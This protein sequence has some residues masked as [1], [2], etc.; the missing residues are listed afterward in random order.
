MKK[1]LIFGSGSIG[2]HMSYASRR[3]KYDVFITDISN[4]ALIRMKK[5]IYPRRY[6]KWDEKIKIIEFKKVFN[7]NYKFDLI[8]I[9]TP[10]KTHLPLY[11]KCLR[12]INCKNILIEKPLAVFNEKLRDNFFLNRTINLYCGYNHSISKSFLYFL[13]I[14]K[15]FEKKKNIEVYWKEGWSGILNAHF[16]MKNEF[17]S[18]L[19]NINK[20]GGSLHEHSHGLHLLFIIL[21]KIQK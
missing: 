8:I 4:D 2:N 5:K 20:G 14:I 9:G 7:L 18:Y 6:G 10:P 21:K 3:L 15:N 16:W 19:G 1:I 13:S 12:Q 17:S 11:K